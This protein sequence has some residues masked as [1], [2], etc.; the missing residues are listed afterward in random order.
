MPAAPPVLLATTIRSPAPLAGG[1]EVS[2]HAAVHECV[3]GLGGVR[4]RGRAAYHG[5]GIGRAVVVPALPDR[6]GLLAARDPGGLPE[7]RLALADAAGDEVAVAGA[8]RVRD[9]AEGRGDVPRRARL[10]LRRVA[11]RP[12]QHVVAV[13][14]EAPGRLERARRRDER[15]LRGCVVGER[16]VRLAGAHVTERLG[17]VGAHIAHRDPLA[18]RHRDEHGAHESR[19]RERRRTL[20]GDPPRRGAGTRR[21]RNQ[22]RGEQAGEQSSHAVTLR[23]HAA[24]VK[25]RTV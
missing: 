9:E 15:R 4:T 17:S 3:T 21:S 18:V 8:A 25:R 2:Q 5:G 12:D 20:D 16:Q 1:L 23:P 24:P 13:E 14:D 22:R 7:G 19:L 6:H 10:D 11:H